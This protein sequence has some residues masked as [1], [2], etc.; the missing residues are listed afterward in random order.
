M[1]Q[2]IKLIISL[3]LVAVALYLVWQVAARYRAAEGTVWERLLAT[4]KDSA[5]IL[6]NKVVAVV[7][8]LVGGLG[9]VAEFAGQPE[10]KTTIE[11]YLGGNPKVLT[12]VLLI[13]AT[14]T[15]FARKRT[16]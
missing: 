1:L 2:N 10:L 14:I 15:I 6:F 9:D 7:A 16:L 8:L 12:V 13:V 3:G 5:T 4:A 11:T